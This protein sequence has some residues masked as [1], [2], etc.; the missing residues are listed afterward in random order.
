[1]PKISKINLRNCYEI[2]TS[3]TDKYLKQGFSR[4]FQ[5]GVKIY[6]SD[7]SRGIF[8][9]FQVGRGHSKTEVGGGQGFPLAILDGGRGGSF[10]VI[11]ASYGGGLLKLARMGGSGGWGHLIWMKKSV[12][13]PKTR[14]K[15]KVIFQSTILKTCTLNNLYGQKSEGIITTYCILT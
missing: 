4:P 14:H 7:P 8:W 15:K 9:V 6:L 3:I 2:L 10:F 11:A 12:F 13:V 1:M 5:M